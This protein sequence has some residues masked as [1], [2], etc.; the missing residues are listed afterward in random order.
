MW[1]KTK[2]NRL[3]F[4]RHAAFVLLCFRFS[5]TP[6]HLY[7]IEWSSQDHCLW[8]HLKMNFT[9]SA[10]NAKRSSIEQSSEDSKMNDDSSCLK[11][12]IAS[13]HDRNQFKVLN[14]ISDTLPNIFVLLVS[15][16]QKYSNLFHCF[17]VI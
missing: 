4:S 1:L 10:F 7:R 12:F 13:S 14:L 9:N 5:K 16:T 11:A 6:C 8:Y 17:R 15:C 2:R 3:I